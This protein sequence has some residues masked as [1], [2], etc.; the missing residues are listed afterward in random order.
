L[1][2]GGP[3]FKSG[4]PD[5]IRSEVRV[6]PIADLG[7]A[8]PVVRQLTRA[9]GVSASLLAATPAIAGAASSVSFITL[10]A[11]SALDP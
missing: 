8:L 3:R 11:P 10:G 4:R 2:A 6:V 1:G 7:D 9:A 5:P